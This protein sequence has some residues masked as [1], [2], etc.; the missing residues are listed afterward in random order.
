MITEAT[1][2][3]FEVQCRRIVGQLHLAKFV[4]GGEG[5]SIAYAGQWLTPNQFEK[6]AGSRSKKYKVSLFV[7]KKPLRKLLEEMN[8]LTRSR[9]VSSSGRKTS[10]SELD[11]E[12][13]AASPR[14]ARKKKKINKVQE[15][16]LEESE[17]DADMDADAEEEVTEIRSSGRIR[18]NIENI[19]EKKR[20]AEEQDNL[21]EELDRKEREK[22]KLRTQII[23]NLTKKRC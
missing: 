10:L 15:V 6:E 9:S 23:K 16:L 21:L 22:K 17:S 1:A 12:A 14:P 5:K 11:S 8:I 2:E 4:S 7:N 3:V 19:K 20:I 18:R 13:S